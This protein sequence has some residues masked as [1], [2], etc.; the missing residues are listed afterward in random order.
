MTLLWT[1]PKYPYMSN[2]NWDHVWIADRQYIDNPSAVGLWL[3]A[4][5]EIALTATGTQRPAWAQDWGT[6]SKVGSVTSNGTSNLMIGD[7]LA[8]YVTGFQ[9]CAIG[10]VFELLTNPITSLQDLL[11]FSNSTDD[12]TGLS[13]QTSSIT[14]PNSHPYRATLEASDGTIATHTLN[15]DADNNRNA[16]TFSFIRDSGTGTYTSSSA[17]WNNNTAAL[18]AVSPL[19]YSTKTLFLNRFTVFGYRSKTTTLFYQHKIRAIMFARSKL[20]STPTPSDSQ[21]SSM[22]Y[23]VSEAA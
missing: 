5:G 4:K 22:A 13:I 14:S 12:N 15:F 7:G 23:S 18:V 21:K 10:V 8:A 20:T 3:P 1:P 16:T 9:E 17:M 2:P 11:S 6:G 19:N